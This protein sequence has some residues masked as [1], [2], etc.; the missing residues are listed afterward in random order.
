MELLTRE[1]QV[2]VLDDVVVEL[3]ELAP[4]ALDAFLVGDL[5]QGV[6]GLDLVLAVALL[7]LLTGRGGDGLLGALGL[8]GGRGGALLAARGG[9]LGLAL[10]LRL[11]GLARGLAGAGVHA[12]VH[13]VVGEAAGA[14]AGPGARALHV[15]ELLGGGDLLVLGGQVGARGVLRTAG[16]G[17]ARLRELQP[18]V[19]AVAG[20]DGPVAAGLAL[21]DGVP[22]L[23]GGG[24]SVGGAHQRDGHGGTGDARE[25]GET[26]GLRGAAVLA[27]A[28]QQHGTDLLTDAYEVSCRVRADELPGRA[29]LRATSPQAVPVRPRLRRGCT[30][31]A[32]YLGPPLLPT[33]LYASVPFDRRQDSA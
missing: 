23:D 2:R 25:G 8:G 4:A 6:A 21:G 12:R 16:G 14:G 27:L 30:D 29:T 10:G 15:E 13:T 1:D 3:E 33:A 20:V 5:A 18:A 24:G 22:G 26:D 28:V 17:P 9:L 19:V 32:A 11:L 31:P 7:D